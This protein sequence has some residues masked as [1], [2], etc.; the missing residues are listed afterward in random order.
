[1]SKLRSLLLKLGLSLV[2]LLLA[3]EITLRLL[4]YAS[5]PSQYYDPQIGY[6]FYPN[7]ERF[8]VGPEGEELADI[9]TNEMGYRGPWYGDAKPEGVKRV[10]CL[11][12][13]FTFGWG[14]N[15]AEAF[16][17]RLEALLA[18]RA[19][20]TGGPAPQVY[21]LGVPGYNTRNELSTYVHHARALDPDVVVLSYFLN[22]LQPDGGG[23]RYTD[24]F[25]FQLFGKTA[26]ADAFHKHLRRKIPLFHAGRSD[27]LKAHMQFY[28]KNFQRIQEEPQWEG[29]RPFWEDS[30]GALREL[31]DEVRADGVKMMLVVFPGHGQLAKARELL[32]AGGEAAV[33]ADGAFPLQ[34]EVR[35]VAGELEL[36]VLDVTALFAG[37]KENPFGKLDPTH[38]G[39]HGY[40]IASRAIA[41]RLVELGY[42]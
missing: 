20:Q 17:I 29:A 32:A 23:P 14:V 2:V 26:M 42:L 34:Q 21:N 10:F 41:K 30:M 33:L 7:Q 39:A 31:V 8:Q 16:P 4:G 18:E 1:M 15:G 40:G 37:S 19:Q 24:T 12:D 22:D 36:P 5:G 9:V 35:R 28:K 25:L 3:A 11:G 13:S 38:P 6:R 27:E